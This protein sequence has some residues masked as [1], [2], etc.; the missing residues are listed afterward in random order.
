VSVALPESHDDLSYVGFGEALPNDAY[1][2]EPTNSFLFRIHNIGGI[3]RV[4]AAVGV[5]E[6]L[7]QAYPYLAEFHSIGDITPGV[8]TQFRIQRRDDLVTL[9]SPDLNAEYTFKLSQY[10]GLFDREHAYLFFGSTTEGT[11]FR[12]FSVTATP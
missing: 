11:R 1:N 7:N 9:S 4:D 8:L 10:P 3:R 2:N 12:Y 6:P 5:R